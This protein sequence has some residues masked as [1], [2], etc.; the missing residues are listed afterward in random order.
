M[1]PRKI[2]LETTTRCNMRCH[3][4]VKTAPG[5]RIEERDFPMRLLPAL[6]SCLERADALI[7]NGVGEPLLHPDLTA[8]TA[9]ARER[10]PES[11]W[12]GFQTN[13]LLLRDALAE[14]LVR[15]GIGKIC[16]SVDCLD[17]VGD[18]SSGKE[19]H[20]GPDAHKL[21]K[22]MRILE[23]A[24]RASAR[25]L[26]VGVESVLMRDSFRQLPRLVRWAAGRGASF[27]LVTHALPYKAESVSQSLF[28]PNTEKAAAIHAKWTR[29]MREEGLDPAGYFKAVM[30][31][32]KS[33]SDKALIALMG[34][35]LEDA[36]EQGVWLNLESLMDLP[37][38]ELAELGAVLDEARAIA[39]QAGMRIETPPLY[40]RDERNCEFIEDDAAFV[41][42]DGAVC[43]CY[44]LWHGYSCVMDGAEKRITRKSFGFL[45]DASLEAI[46]ND[47]G[48]A[49]FRQEVRRYEYPFCNNCSLVPCDDLLGEAYPFEMDCLGGTVPCG[50]CQWCMGG[51]RCLS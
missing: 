48:Y 26:S 37:E 19:I 23:R 43:P 27:F 40:A 22:A 10:M 29:R 2:Y 44:F 11:A 25:G 32:D 24:G 39:R 51:L 38:G 34:K 9:Y 31:Y 3:M 4:C 47:P 8:M 49:A 14:D 13:G 12:I 16:L 35:M 42:A 33:A 6:D 18:A 1:F 17:A 50:H 36:R 7:L 28:H 15:A 41:A 46:W 5:A 30:R 45:E 21:D 20:G